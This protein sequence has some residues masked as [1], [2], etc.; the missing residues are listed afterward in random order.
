[1]LFGLVPN[2]FTLLYSGCI[3]SPGVEGKLDEMP[4]EMPDALSVC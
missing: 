2:L 3:M 4:D 1:M